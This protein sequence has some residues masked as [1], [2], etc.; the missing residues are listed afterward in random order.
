MTVPSMPRRNPPA[1]TAK[2]VTAV[3]HNAFCARVHLFR[4]CS[5]LRFTRGVI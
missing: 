5:A 3:R 2:F 4:R 1:G